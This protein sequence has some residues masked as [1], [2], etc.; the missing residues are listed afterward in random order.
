MCS[1]DIS[2]IGAE[3]HL[4]NNHSLYVAKH[5]N[6]CEECGDY[7]K[8]DKKCGCDKKPTLPQVE[9]GFSERSLSSTSTDIDLDILDLELPWLSHPSN[10]V[11]K[12]NNPNYS[13]TS[14][15]NSGHLK[16]EK[17]CPYIWS[18]SINLSQGNYVSM[19]KVFKNIS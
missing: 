18:W 15:E 7:F 6:K 12:I 19:C 10:F 2:E 4:K 17:T 9:C 5:W 11:D 16:T 14:K 3:L 13:K 8:T 1:Q